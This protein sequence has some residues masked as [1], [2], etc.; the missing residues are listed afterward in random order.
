MG[1]SFSSVPGDRVRSEPPS[2]GSGQPDSQGI[3]EP[4]RGWLRSGRRPNKAISDLRSGYQSDINHELKWRVGQCFRNTFDRYPS[5][6]GRQNLSQESSGRIEDR[7]NLRLEIVSMELIWKESRRNLFSYS[8][9]NKIVTSMPKCSA[10]LP[11]FY[12]ELPWQELQSGWEASC[13]NWQSRF[14]CYGCL[15]Q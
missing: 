6:R 3:R 12:D 14:S 15:C 4:D 2:Q 11:D 10:F 1:W 13:G 9:G 7:V 5:S 8:T